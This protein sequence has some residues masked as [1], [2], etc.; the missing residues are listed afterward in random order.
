MT[1]TVLVELRHARYFCAVADEQ[2]FG[3]AATRLALS[4]PSLSVQISSRRTSARGS[5][6]GT[7]VAFGSPTQAA[8]STTPRDASCALGR[9]RGRDATRRA[10]V[11]ETGTIRVGFGPSLMLATLAQVIRA[12]RARMPAIVVRD[13]SPVDSFRRQGFSSSLQTR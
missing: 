3:R 1:P 4:Q 13:R 10:G 9:R 2:H 7:A 8:C 6:I 12:Y 5:S 11:G